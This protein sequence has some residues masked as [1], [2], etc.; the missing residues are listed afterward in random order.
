M[1][2]HWW[3]SI[4]WY[5]VVRH[6]TSR[7]DPS[8]CLFDYNMVYDNMKVLL[9]AMLGF[10]ISGAS[11]YEDLNTQYKFIEFIQKH[12]KQYSSSGEYME[13]L[14]I[15]AQTLK[16]IEN[17]NSQKDKTWTKGI[18]QFSDLTS[19]F[20]KTIFPITTCI[21]ILTKRLFS[22]YLLNWLYQF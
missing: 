10:T 3:S 16:D 12:N 11:S 1:F 15:F 22:Y 21:C 9:L 5:C 13:R 6:S 4:I 14:Q 17:H 20:I 19:K 7:T 8:Q 18:N 2:R